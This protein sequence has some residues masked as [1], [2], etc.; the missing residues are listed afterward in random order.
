[1]QRPLTITARDFA[2]SDAFDA[3]IREKAAGLD[4]YFN[5]ITGCDVTVEAPVDHHRKGGPF[6]VQIRL[7]VPGR[8]L[9]AN[10]QSEEGLAA[11]VRESFDAIQ[12]QLED[13]VREHRGAAKVHE[14]AAQARV[15]K[16]FP[17]YGFLETPDGREIYFHCNSVLN[18]GFE[19]LQ[20]GT[21]VHFAEEQGNEG[22]QA[23][24]VTIAERKH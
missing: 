21:H 18:D 10:H 13:Y 20:V 22:P 9:M 23:S 2:L 19:K 14:E 1:M 6:A 5:R 15:S 17:D 24:T 11:A 12:R 8:E 4:T 7:T 3:E 16:L